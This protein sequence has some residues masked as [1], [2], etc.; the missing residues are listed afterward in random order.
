MSKHF[1]IFLLLILFFRIITFDIS[2]PED[3]EVILRGQILKEVSVYEDQQGITLNNYRIYLDKYPSL[4]YGDVVEIRG[5]VKDNKLKNAKLISKANGGRL[6]KLRNFLIHRVAS[7]L[8]LDN[9]A[10]VNGVVFGSKEFISKDFWN[11]LVE[12]GTAHVVV[13]SGTNVVLTASFLINLLIV[14]TTRKKAIPIALVGIW[15]YVVM[16]G[17]EAPLVRAATMGSIAFSAQGLGRLSNT[18]DALALSVTSMLIYNPLW[19]TDIGFQL[20]LMATLSLIL[21]ES[22]VNRSIQFVPSILRQDLSTSLA[23]Q[24]GVAPLLMIHFGR[25]NLISPF[26]NM[27]VLWTIPPLMILGAIGSIVGWVVLVFTYPF[28]FFFIYIVNIFSQ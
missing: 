16:S 20:S 4:Q 9:A 12:S 21:F 14:F 11:R 25:I 1:K 27:L 18:L 17:F 6:F 2:L 15:F 3:K 24:V 8:P 22:F 7:N 19:L 10:L 26:V 28:S 13:A 5:F 23:A